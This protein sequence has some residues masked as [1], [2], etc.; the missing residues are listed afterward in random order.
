M[1]RIHALSTLWPKLHRLHPNYSA[2]GLVG[3]AVLGLPVDDADKLLRNHLVGDLGSVQTIVP[4]AFDISNS[5]APTG[6]QQ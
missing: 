6:S 5:S 4:V 3:L 1:I 2:L